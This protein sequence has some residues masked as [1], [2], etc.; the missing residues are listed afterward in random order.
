[1]KEIESFAVKYAEFIVYLILELIN[2]QGF[3]SISPDMID[4]IFKYRRF[5]IFFM[6]LIVSESEICIQRKFINVGDM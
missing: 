3:K 5:L 2:S 4:V 1:M 6:L